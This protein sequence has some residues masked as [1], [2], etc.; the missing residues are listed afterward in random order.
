MPDT[1][2]LT[3]TILGQQ[4]VAIDD[5]PWTE[6]TI[7]LS[8]MEA[9]HD[10]G[11]APGFSFLISYSGEGLGYLPF[12]VNSI[13]DQRCVYWAVAI[14]GQPPHIG[15]DKQQLNPGDAV[16]LTFA[17][18]RADEAANDPLIATELRDERLHPALQ[19]PV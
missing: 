6:G 9:A 5:L 3:A 16:T 11:D 17:W 8:A 18:C 12:E 13:G 2:S 15:L 1:V 4:L 10:S 7:L 14:N 19:V